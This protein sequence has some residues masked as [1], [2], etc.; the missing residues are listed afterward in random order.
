MADIEQAL[1]EQSPKLQPEEVLNLMPNG[2]QCQHGSQMPPLADD[3]SAVTSSRSKQGVTLKIKPPTGTSTPVDKDD[4]EHEY[5]CV[6]APNYLDLLREELQKVD[7]E[8]SQKL[9]RELDAQELEA[10]A[11]FEKKR[12]KESFKAWQSKELRDF[13]LRVL[14]G[15][16]ITTVV[17]IVGHKVYRYVADT[18]G[19]N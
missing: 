5:T 8:I 17:V 14:C 19:G 7:L 12:S 4:G 13:G 11:R 3:R 6:M 15:L 18:S 10:Q 2:L 16:V 9:D 1:L